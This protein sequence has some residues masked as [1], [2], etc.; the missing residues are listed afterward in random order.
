MA[1]AD[2]QHRHGGDQQKQRRQAKV[3]GT[4]DEAVDAVERVFEHAHDRQPA[5]VRPAAVQQLED[6][7]IGH[8]VDGGGRVAQ[9][10]EHV[11]D[12]LLGP[13]RKRDVNDA[14]RPL[15]GL[16]QQF[17]Q[18][19][20]ALANFAGHARRAARRPIVEEA[21]QSQAHVRRTLDAAGELEAQLRD[22]DNRKAAGIETLGQQDVLGNANH[23]AGQRRGQGH[24]HHPDDGYIA[25]QGM[26]MAGEEAH[27]GQSRQ[28]IKPGDPPAGDL[29]LQDCAM[30]APVHAG[31][32]GHEVEDDDGGGSDQIRSI[33]QRRKG[34]QHQAGDASNAQGIGQSVQDAQRRP[35]F[36]DAP[37]M[38]RHGTRA[39]AGAR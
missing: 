32:L 2:Q 23:P 3:G 13:H 36:V 14:H 15:A 24:K 38:V 19:A 11:L 35:L 5:D 28:R 27:Q 34:P 7:E 20:D 33:I 12:P 21:D 8:Q 22:A 30:P 26:A 17:V 10:I 29:T 1:S 16:L 9:A 25:R 6:E 4:L 39:A 37:R 18:V 31:Q